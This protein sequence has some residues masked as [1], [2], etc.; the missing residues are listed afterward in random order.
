MMQSATIW[1]AIATFA[2]ML[3]LPRIVARVFPALQKPID[4]LTKMFSRDQ[5]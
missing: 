4:L 5:G 3:G 1:L 2:A